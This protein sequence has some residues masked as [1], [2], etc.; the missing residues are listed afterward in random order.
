LSLTSERCSQL[1]A[2]ASKAQ[3]TGDVA[4]ASKL[5][6]QALELDPAFI[7]AK[8]LAGILA[9]RQGQTALAIGYL[10]GV[11]EIEPQSY[12]TL[13]SL[14]NVYL[15][16]GQAEKA[17]IL[18]RKA[19]KARPNDAHAYNHLGR[20]LM[21][22]R[23]LE[24]AIEMFHK[25]VL[26]HPQFA[27]AFHNM[28]KALQLQG[29]ESEAAQAYEHAAQLAPSVTNLLALGQCLMVICSY[30]KAEACARACL[31]QDPNSAPGHLLLCG[32]LIE[33]ERPDE[34]E[35]HLRQAEALDPDFKEAFLLASRQ[36][37]L[38]H[39]REAQENLRR[40]IASQPGFVP[41]YDA[42]VHNQKVAPEDLPLVAQMTAMLAG[43]KLSPTEQISLN[44]A[45]G[46]ANADL[47][48]Y[49]LAMRHYDEA[50]HLSK[51][52]KLRNASFDPERYRAYIDSLMDSFTPFG[53]V[54]GSTTSDLPLLI[55]GMMRSGTTL[56]EQILSSHPQVGAAGEQLFWSAN[57]KRALSDR[58][59]SIVELGQVYVQNLG[60]K[61]PEQ[62]RVTDKMP[63]NYHFAGLIHMAVPNARILHM[64][65]N[66]VDTCLSI[67]MTPNHIPHEGGY[68]KAGIA[69]VYKEYLRLMRHWRRVLPPDRFLEVD[70]EDLVANQEEVTRK[71]VAFCGLQWDQACLA[72]ERNE[73]QI[74]T[75][76][77]WQVRQPVYQSSTEK[78]KK[79]RLWLGEFEE[80]L[81]LSHEE[82]G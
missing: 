21:A 11:L 59:E 63:G 18:G 82:P 80:L 32:A 81:G 7:P 77:L 43:E 14:S 79:Y 23:Q 26:T 64:R 50:N 34:A 67:W 65:R 17:E 33:L 39:I 35:A 5:C 25:A 49:E 29:M 56:A 22:E 30:E 69:F 20:C 53:K 13:V 52:I 2:N 27:P 61:H 75:P 76:S 58:P 16:S 55:I 78:W 47:G 15:E 9:A 38:G 51:L 4:A 36:R 6:E 3:Q 41:A 66:P 24:E 57:W 60:A 37:P 72:P 46:K 48:H 71:I 40:V 45:L 19:L 70:Y 62:R 1:V 8:F 12:E 28:G 31:A 74:S 54:E 10:Q 68:E 42:F 73:R 44:F